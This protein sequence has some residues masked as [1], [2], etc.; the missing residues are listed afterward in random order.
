MAF[1]RDKPKDS[2]VALRAAQALAFG[3]GAGELF[4]DLLPVPAAI[5]EWNGKNF[6]F[7]AVNRPFRL[8]GLGTVA[9]ESPLIRLLGSQLRRFLENLDPEDFGK[10][11]P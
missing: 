1:T 10:Y 3:P 6:V 5:V 4:L 2:D 11:N 7:D 9:T 8:A